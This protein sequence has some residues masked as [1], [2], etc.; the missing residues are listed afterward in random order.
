M[1]LQGRGSLPKRQSTSVLLCRLLPVQLEPELS[2]L[3]LWRTVAMA[4]HGRALAI[5][6]GDKNLRLADSPRRALNGARAIFSGLDMRK[7]V[8]A[9]QPL[10]CCCSQCFVL[11]LSRGARSPS[12][13]LSLSLSSPAAPLT[14]LR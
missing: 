10:L 4:R 11:L 14:R 6:E 3:P 8:N 7:S 1:L 2:R 9:Q 5:W 13:F 12:L